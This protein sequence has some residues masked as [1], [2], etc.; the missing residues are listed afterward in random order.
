ML[1]WKADTLK[2]VRLV[3]DA[4]GNMYNQS[5]STHAF[6]Q[7]LVLGFDWCSNTR[8]PAS[9]S[10]FSVD[11]TT[12]QFDSKESGRTT[13]KL[14]IIVSLHQGFLL[15]LNHFQNCLNWSYCDGGLPDLW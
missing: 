13:G 7:S 15:C 10:A 5:D 1:L 3:P 11:S 2:S 4:V 14:L 9:Q 6:E 8:Y 12:F